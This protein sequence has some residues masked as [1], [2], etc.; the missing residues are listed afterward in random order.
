MLSLKKERKKSKKSKSLNVR[1][2]SLLL[3]SKESS[4][5]K[6]SDLRNKDCRSLGITK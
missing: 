6:R 1:N 2:S 5:K 4:K 3:K